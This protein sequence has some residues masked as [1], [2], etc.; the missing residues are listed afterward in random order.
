MES[1]IYA[2]VRR[3]SWRQQM[4]ILALSA[5]LLPL[6]YVTL[7]LPKTIVNQALGE[8][9]RPVF[10]G[11]SFDRLDLLWLLCGLFLAAVLISGG[12]KYIVNVYAGI[13]SERMLRRLRYQLYSNILR[14]PLHHFRRTSQG[15][16]V[17][18]I[19][20]ETEPL[21]GFVAE[22]VSTPGLQGGTLLTTLVFIF[23]Q[24][25]ILGLAAIALYPLQIYLIPKLQ[26]QVN[27][28][29]KLRVQQ[30]RRNAERISETVQGVRDIH[31]NDG[32]RYERA[33]FAQ[34]L[35]EVFWI[36]FD[37]YKKKFLIKFLN[38]FMAQFGPFLFFSIGG[39][40]VL[41]GEVSLGA[42]VAVVSA[43]K[44]ISAPWKEL[45]TFYQGAYDV[46][47]KYEQVV[48]QFLPPDLRRE[49]LIDGKADE[50]FEI[51]GTLKA[52]NLA[53]G[54]E[55]GEALI[56][57]IG[58]ELDLPAKL[59]VVGPAGAGKEDLVVA[60][61]GLSVPEQGR[62]TIDGRDL[63]DIPEAALSRK[64]AFVG[65]QPYVFAGTV[66]QNLVYGLMH[67]PVAPRQSEDEELERELR[68]ANLSG[69]MA[70]DVE[71]D[72]IAFNEVGLDGPAA[73]QEEILRI[74]DLVLLSDDV[75]EQGLRGHIAGELDE[76]ARAKIIEA[77]RLVD[78]RLSEDSRLQRLIERFDPDRYNNNA[79]LADNLLF[80]TPKNMDFDVNKIAQYPHMRETLQKTGLE[81]E[82]KQVGYKLAQ[83][84]VELFADLPPDHDYYRQFSFIAPDELPDFRAMI[85]RASAGRLD[86]LSEAEQER[87]LSLPF[88]LVDTRHRLGLLTDELKA[89]VV[90]ARHYFREHLPERLVDRIDFFD[91]EGINQTSS[92][93]DNII[94][95]RIAYGQA[96]AQARISQL[97]ASVIDELDL[98][99]AIMRIGL[100]AQVGVSG[101]RLPVAQRQKLALARAILKRPE[102]LLLVDP[103]GPL[104]TNEQE[105]VRDN[106]LKE[107]AERT[108]IWAVHQS[109][110]ALAF[111][112]VLVME[113]GHMRT[114]G[115][116]K[117][118]MEQLGQEDRAKRG[119]LDDTSGPGEEPQPPPA[120]AHM[121]EE[122][123]AEDAESGEKT[124]RQSGTTEPRE[125]EKLTP[126][127]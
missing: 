90:E 61:S 107:F 92:V 25:P 77:R 96:G 15:E 63:H 78:E 52:S 13:V 127:K 43:H 51:K 103:T 66:Y 14:F 98:R 58:F 10:M 23:V 108:V 20:G 114:I 54:D 122:E 89:K 104:D 124:T 84:M 87:L 17:T 48:T 47:I 112:M 34:Q 46:K 59:A 62:V 18:M 36:R 111:D 16:I 73:Q 38:N 101:S 80:G 24:N 93:Q 72:W 81:Q 113:R 115:P 57:G 109:Q 121:D 56:E 70:L 41:N 106:I 69:N 75:Y 91:P 60:L 30:V 126:A 28:L 83:T 1:S 49:E 40:L 55:S 2:F 71:A 76:E 50:S 7:E 31:A 68:E 4:V 64:V 82:L 21:G 74:L 94:F 110:W 117:T 8:K 79:T 99:P 95:G 118:V 116:S 29:G 37:I 97:I 120:H 53:I 12:L 33:R 125:Q 100:D 105:I 65:T 32:S 22:A 119:P 44:D 19:N 42:L 123:P 27:Q 102:M 86:R 88:K 67:E 45:L 35:G 11:Y 9:A 39:Y 5:I 85:G 3:Y 6:N 26:R